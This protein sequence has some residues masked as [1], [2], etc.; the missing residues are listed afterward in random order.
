MVN[1]YKKQMLMQ[2]KLKS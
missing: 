2:I 1:D